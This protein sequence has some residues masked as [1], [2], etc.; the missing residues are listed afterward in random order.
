MIRSYSCGIPLV[1]CT[2]S[3]SEAPLLSL[4]CFSSLSHLPSRSGVKIN[5]FLSLPLLRST[6]LT[7]LIAPDKFSSKVCCSSHF[8]AGNDNE[9]PKG[10]YL[11]FLLLILIYGANIH[12]RRLLMFYSNRSNI[13]LLKFWE[14]REYTGRHPQSYLLLL[15]IV[16]LK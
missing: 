10:F 14:E 6:L 1:L 15:I 4:S 13:C 9:L 8:L 7:F 5:P 3:T 2:S 16:L 12:E 11:L